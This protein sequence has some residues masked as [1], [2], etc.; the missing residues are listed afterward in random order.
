[1]G[2]QNA[3]RH[4][5]ND[6]RNAPGLGRFVPLLTIAWSAWSR[7][8]VDDVEGHATVGWS[9]VAPL[10]RRYTTSVIPPGGGWSVS[11]RGLLPGV[12]AEGGRDDILALQQVDCRASTV[13]R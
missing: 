3:A 8:A 12:I 10:S 5:T 9:V 2:L 6:P 11:L 4:V 7:V 1:M 13:R